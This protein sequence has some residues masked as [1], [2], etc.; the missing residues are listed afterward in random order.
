MSSQSNK[1]LVKSAKEILKGLGHDISTGHIYELFSKLSGVS[2]HNVARAQGIQ[3]A[4]VI[5]Q[6]GKP[7]TVVSDIS[8]GDKLFEVKIKHDTPD[9]E[10]NK[11]Y[12]ITAESET[13]AR[14]IVQEYIDVRTWEIKESEVKYPQTL[15]L[16]E[17]E[18]ETEFEYQNWELV[19]KSGSPE[20]SDVYERSEEDRQ[21]ELRAYQYKKKAKADLEAYYK[22]RK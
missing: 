15:L 11:F 2:S 17:S 4:T 13:Q 21:N 20:I 12:L 16:M 6:T 3:F 1:D 10:L 22:N 9:T 19:T 7:E 5:E 8:N 14:A 18:D